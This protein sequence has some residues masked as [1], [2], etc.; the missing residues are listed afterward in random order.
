MA[1]YQLTLQCLRSKY[2][3]PVVNWSRLETLQIHV[4]NCPFS[5]DSAT[6]QFKFVCRDRNKERP[7]KNE[8][9]NTMEISHV[10]IPTDKFEFLCCGIRTER[11]RQ[12]WI[13]KC[14]Q[15]WSIYYGTP[16]FGSETLERQLMRRHVLTELLRLNQAT[17][18]YMSATV[19]ILLQ[20]TVEN[21]LSQTAIT[22]AKNYMTHPFPIYTWCQRHLTTQLALLKGWRMAGR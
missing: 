20:H 17:F 11:T 1:S 19:P 18:P 13:C 15:P 3:G 8:D 4:C 5:S 16:I 14:F 2:W 9:S 10:A 12:T 22:L 21:C 7:V 6:Q